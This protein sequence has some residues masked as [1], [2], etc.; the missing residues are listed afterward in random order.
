MVTS[1]SFMLDSLP[2]SNLTAYR[3]AID[4]AGTANELVKRAPTA[5]E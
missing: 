1:G 4:A 3:K 2:T 5:A